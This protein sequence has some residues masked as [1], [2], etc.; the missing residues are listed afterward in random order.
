MDDHQ[1][2]SRHEW[3]VARQT[4]LAQEK[5]LTRLRD[6]VS[7][8]RRA[9]PWV[10]VEKTYVFEGPHGPETLADLFAGRRQLLIYHFMFGPTWEEGCPSC[11]FWADNYNGIIVH[12][13]Q[14]DVTMVT[15][16]RAPWPKLEAYKQR[17]GWSFKWVSSL[18]TDFNCDYHVSFTDEA[19]Q[20]GEAYY[21]YTT[22]RTTFPSESVGISV[23]YQDTRGEVFHTYSCYARGVEMVNGAYHFLDLLPQGRDEASLSSPQAWVRRHDQ[24]D[25]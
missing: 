2:V 17:M 12:L 19:R 14:R 21:N 1:V 25:D 8:Q 15:V 11:S 24:Y 23:F 9:L 5:A 18:G 22:R 7:Q 10:R 20:E 13:Q 4:L 3:L 6:Q 16:S